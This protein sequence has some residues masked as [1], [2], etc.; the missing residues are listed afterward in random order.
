MIID[1]KKEKFYVYGAGHYA[2]IFMSW[3]QLQHMDD[4]VQAFIVSN[5]GEHQEE[6]CGRTLVGYD[7]VADKLKNEKIYI[8]VS[9]D[10]S[11]GIK[12]K[13]TAAGADGSQLTDIS[14]R[15]MENELFSAC[16]SNN[17][18]L[19]YI[20]VWNY[21]GMGYY[22]QCK[23][24][25][26][27]VHR[28]NKDIRFYWILNEGVKAELPGWVEPVIIGSYKYY[29][30]MSRARILL[31]NVD[32]PSSSRFKRKYQ[33]FIYTWHGI[34]PSKRLEWESPLHRARVN[35]DKEVIKERWNG[36]DVMIAGSDFCHHVYRKSFLYDGLIENWGYPRNDVFFCKVSYEEK[37]RKQFNIERAKRII[38]YAPTFRNE[39]MENKDEN[40]LKEIYDI[41][42]LLV[43]KA[44]DKRFN[45]DFVILYRFHHYVHRYVDT[46]SYKQ[47]GIDVTDYLDMQEL[48][49]M[50]DILI[51]DYS[52]SM[53]DFS[54][55]RKPVFLYYHDA[56]EYEEK[57]Q[58]FYVF[59][60]EY[61][62][63]KGHTTEELCQE[64]LNF[65]EKKYQKKLDEWFARFGSYDD[66]HA[67]EKVADRIFDVLNN[68][69]KYGKE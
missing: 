10:I 50:T 69:A 24:I 56:E 59:P 11:Y 31:T 54:L 49:S 52:S 38:L 5:R 34:G 47:N 20:L 2:R 68:S 44:A 7:E 30:V 46:S 67:S 29:E 21:W 39:L 35:N 57:Y 18:P 16:S 27:E 15:S 13:L 6:F 23:Y 17:I 33:Y 65:D 62:Y 28:R 48:L 63:P 40:R 64:I 61:P 60:D 14:M 41:N 37:I 43:K 3:L 26:E 1:V 25:A 55:T 36:A 12:E 53:W 8:A 4:R 51:T 66:G 45:S 22:D 32:A 9:E 19:D 58:G 42:L